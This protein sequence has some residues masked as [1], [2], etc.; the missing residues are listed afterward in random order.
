MTFAGLSSVS[1][2]YRSWSDEALLSYPVPLCVPDWNVA[3]V[4]FQTYVSDAIFGSLSF[5]A[6]FVYLTAEAIDRQL[7]IEEAAT[8]RHL[9]GTVLK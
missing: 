4:R 5:L 9:E 7:D 1:T 6:G 3:G 8:K 2:L